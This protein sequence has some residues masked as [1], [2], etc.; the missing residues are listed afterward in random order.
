MHKNLFLYLFILILLQSCSSKDNDKVVDK[1]LEQDLDSQMI[2]S[3][4]EGFEALNVGDGY[5]A[6]KKFSEAEIFYPQSKWAPRSSLMTAYSYY[7]VNLYTDAIAEI[8]RYLKTYPL[9]ERHNY[10]YYLLA[11]SYYEQI[12]DEK[13]DLGPLIDAKKYFEI[14]LEKYPKSEFAYDAEYKLELIIEMIAAK[15]MYLGRYYL[16]K[17]KWIA[18]M[19]RFKNVVENYDKTIYIEEALFRLVE[20]YYRIGLID[21]AKAA[22]SLLGYNYNSSEWYEKSYTV[23]NKNYKPA[24]IEGDKEEKNLVNRIKKIFLL[25]D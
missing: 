6:A 14:I 9:H 5:T 3:Y 21:E 1:I 20:I 13:K 22:A 8:N 11:L 15:E 17:E 24:K 19:N 7:S 10:A 12:V 25:N 16:E 23:L 4:N 18:A 2:E